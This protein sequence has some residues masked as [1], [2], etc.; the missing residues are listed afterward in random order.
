MNERGS[1]TRGVCAFSR[2]KLSFHLFD[3]CFPKGLDLG[4]P[5]SRR[6]KISIKQEDDTLLFCDYDNRK[7][8]LFLWELS[9]T[10]L[11]THVD[12]RED[13]HGYPSPQIGGLCQESAENIDHVFI[14]CPFVWNIWT[15]LLSSFGWII[16][17]PQSIDHLFTSTKA[18]I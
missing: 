11:N 10:C 17:P 6:P 13:A 16:V 7:L 18:M 9:N 8:K 2:E 3:Q 15:D 14:Y 12:Y 1:T 5:L 4:F